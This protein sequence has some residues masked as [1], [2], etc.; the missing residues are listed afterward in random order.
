LAAKNETVS[1]ALR[2]TLV[3][4]HLTDSGNVEVGQCRED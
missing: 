1:R 3:D 4:R 2:S